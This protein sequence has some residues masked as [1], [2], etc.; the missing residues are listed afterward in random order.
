[1]FKC[2]LGAWVRYLIGNDK[3]GGVYRICEISSKAILTRIESH[4]INSMPFIT[5][6]GPDLVKP[7]RI[8]DQLVDRNL[9]LK[10]G[11]AQK[12]FPMDKVSNGPFEKVSKVQS[13]NCLIFFWF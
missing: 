5:D 13:A 9:E 8:D 11:N 6:L 3:G 10:H 7:Y 1:M 2:L 4:V 12:V